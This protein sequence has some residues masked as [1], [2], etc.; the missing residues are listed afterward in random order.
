MNK[1]NVSISRNDKLDYIRY[2]KNKNR[3]FNEIFTNILQFTFIQFTF[4]RY[5]TDKLTFYSGKV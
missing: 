3:I 2:T 1:S 5:K 4:I